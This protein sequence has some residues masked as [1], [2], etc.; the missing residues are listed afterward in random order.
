MPT[1]DHV[2]PAPERSWPLPPPCPFGPSP[3]G[4]GWF[5]VTAMPMAFSGCPDAA[6]LGGIL[7]PV[8]SDRLLSH[9]RLRRA[10]QDRPSGTCFTGSP[11][12]WEL[13]PHDFRV[14]RE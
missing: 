5:V 11:P 9:A 6:M 13:H 12:G 10:G 14:V 1:Y 7:D 2:T 4:F 3:T 8:S